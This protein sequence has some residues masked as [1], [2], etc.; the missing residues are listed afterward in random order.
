[1]QTF[2]RKQATLPKR[3]QDTPLRGSRCVSFH[4]ANPR[5]YRLGDYRAADPANHPTPCLICTRQVLVIHSRV[6]LEYARV[7][8]LPRDKRYL[9]RR[10]YVLQVDRTPP[11]Q[12]SRMGTR[13]EGAEYNTGSGFGVI[14]MAGNVAEWTN[15]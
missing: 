13:A 7:C 1:M 9:E 3:A 5:A 8:R 6:L 14:D 10:R 12:Q 11:A 15:K 2:V 4:P